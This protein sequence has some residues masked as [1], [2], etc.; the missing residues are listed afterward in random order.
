MW[1]KTSVRAAPPRAV[2]SIRR[3]VLAMARA[4]IPSLALALL[5]VLLISGCVPSSC[6][7]HSLSALAGVYASSANDVWAAGGM[8]ARSNGQAGLIEHWDGTRWAVAVTSEASSGGADFPPSALALAAVAGSGADDVWAVG[9]SSAHSPGP[10]VVH[11][12]GTAWNPGVAPCYTSCVSS[13]L[14]AVAV[15]SPTDAWAVGV[16]HIPGGSVPADHPLVE[17]WDGTQWQLVPG[18]DALSTDATLSSLVA[19][20]ATDVWVFGAE[21]HYYAFIAHWDGRTW[22]VVAGASAPNDQLPLVD[23]DTTLSAAASDPHAVSQP[24][25]VVGT[26]FANP[27][28]DCKLPLILRGSDGNWSVLSA[29]QVATGTAASPLSA[30]SLKAVGVVG[31]ADAWAV[32]TYQPPKGPTVLPGRAFT[33]HWDGTRWQD[34]PVPAGQTLDELDGV[35][36]VSAND[37]WAVGS[38]TNLGSGNYWSHTLVTHW[39]GASWTVVPSPNPGATVPNICQ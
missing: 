4:C 3:S 8:T 1:P 15:L 12:D 33:A 18:S 6:G 14:N 37:V 22:R 5:G 20:S 34:V 29:A 39:D 26:T 35:V 32:G 10:A 36:A 21:Q 28:V 24:I 25:W 23:I 30:V 17:H 19:F 27:C 11:W 16:A 9:G 38:S 31:S 7:T 2:R 13:Q